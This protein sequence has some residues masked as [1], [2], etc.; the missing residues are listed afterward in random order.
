MIKCEF[1]FD[2]FYAIIVDNMTVYSPVAPEVAAMSSTAAEWADPLAKALADF[3]EI[4]TWLETDVYPVFRAASESVGRSDGGS[5]ESPRVRTETSEPTV[6]EPLA[7]TTPKGWFTRARNFVSERL[8]SGSE[9]VNLREGVAYLVGLAA[10]FEAVTKGS[11]T[12]KALDIKGTVG[13]VLKGFMEL[14]VNPSVS[15]HAT[16][17]GTF[18]LVGFSAIGMGFAMH[19]SRRR[20]NRV[21]FTETGFVEPANPYEPETSSL[22]STDFAT[23]F[24]M[25][26][27]HCEGGIRDLSAELEEIRRL[28]DSPDA[29]AK[30][31]A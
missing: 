20:R 29:H 14:I 3:D 17:M 12:L 27:Q 26:Q 4:S 8:R 5:M 10:T 31:T 6:I 25:Y 9:K 30:A 1:E 16:S 2:Q 13:G 19:E 11:E 23:S 15:E 18:S 21:A 22:D 24:A 28:V 7:K